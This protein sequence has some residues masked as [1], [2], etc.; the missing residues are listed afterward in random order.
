MAEKGKLLYSKLLIFKIYQNG[1]QPS[2]FSYLIWDFITFDRIIGIYKNITINGYTIQ[3]K[4]D[5]MP[6]TNKSGLPGKRFTFYMKE[7]EFEKMLS[8]LAK[9][10][11]SRIKDIYKP[12][13]MLKIKTP[14]RRF[15]IIEK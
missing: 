1:I 8:I 7:S 6:E 12:N 13:R 2:K 3:Y 15:E 5:N 11:G 9:Q 14:Y 10:I 4:Y